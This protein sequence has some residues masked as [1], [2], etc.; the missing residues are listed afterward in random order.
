M[1]FGRADASKQDVA[2][3]QA[4]RLDADRLAYRTQRL[5]PSS[6]RVPAGTT[7][8]DRI[9]RNRVRRSPQPHYWAARRW[10]TIRRENPE[11]EIPSLAESLL[12]IEQAR[13]ALAIDPDDASSW[14]ILDEAYQSLVAGEA[15]ILRQSAVGG[16]PTGYS[17]FRLQQRL[18]VLNFLIQ[19]TPPPT[20][21]AS[22]DFLANLH[23]E[24][25]RSTW[26][27]VST[28]SPATSWSRRASWPGSTAF[29]SR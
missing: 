29:R 15:E 28:I 19:S 6:D 21:R 27:R 9:F 8:L 24:L 12:A 13:A 25:R 3:F 26:I 10:L 16:V 5:V 1:L 4:N 20:S 14:N 7:W 2:F 17:R 11:A 23:Q 22:R 18:T